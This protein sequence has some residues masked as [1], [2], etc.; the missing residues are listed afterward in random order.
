MAPRSSRAARAGLAS[1][2]ATA[3]AL[4][5]FLTAG[6]AAL[7]QPSG[8]A[9]PV[10]VVHAYPVT[11]VTGDRLVV[12]ALSNGRQAV[13]VANRSS[14]S[15]TA[16]FST[17]FH[18][19][20][21]NGDMY[22]WPVDYGPYVG[23][24][25]D[26]ELFNVSKLVR[27]GYSD[28]ASATIPLI[29]DYRQLPPEQALLPGDVTKTRSLTS[30]GAVAGRESKAKAHA[31]GQALKQQLEADA[32]AIEKGRRSAIAR[33]GPFAGVAKVYLDQKI[34][35]ALADSVPQIGAPQ[36]WAAGFTG[37]G[38]DVAVLDTGI[39]S[40]H[41]DLQ[42]K[43]VA[44]ANFTPDPTAADG[45]GHGTHVADTVAGSGTASNGLRKGVA[46]GAE[47][48]NGK[49]LDSTG[50]GQ[51]SWVIAGMQWAATNGADV[52]SMSLQAGITDGTDPVSQAVNQLTEGD[53]VLFT[54]AAGNFGSSPQTVTS[55]GAANDALTVGA[56][57]KQNVLAGFSGRG[58]RFGDFALKPDIT[59]PGVNIIAAR[60]AGT[61]LGTPIDEFYTMLSGTSMATPHIA[62]SAAIL[63]QEFPSMTPAQLK[64]A[65]MSTALPGPYTVYQQGAG[66]VDVAR[67]YSQ[68]VYSNNSP[69]DF[70]YFPYPHDNDQP[71]TKSISYSNYTSAAV[72]LNLTADVTGQDGNP[73]APGMVTTSAPSVTI[74][75]GGTASVDVTVDTRVGDPSLYGGVIRAE[76]S[77]GNVVVRTPVGFYKEPVRFN[78]TVDGIARDGRP[79]RGISWI[80]IVNADDTTRFQRTVGL[81]GGPVTVRVP[82]GT[83]S[84]MGFLFT[85][86]EPQVFATEATIAGNPQLE[87]NQDTTYTADARPAT[88]VIENTDKPTQA[89]WWVIGHYRAAEHLGSF[90]SLL[91]ASPPINRMF[92]APTQQVTKGDFGFRAK[93]NLEAPELEM[94]IAPPHAMPLDV[95]YASGA[96]KIDGS[97][98]LPLVYAGYGRVQDF[99]GLD[100]QGKAVLMTRGPLPP[101]GNPITFAEKVA[102][103]TAAGARLAII[104]NHSPG[105]LL[106]GLDPATT[107]I[108]VFSTSKIDGEQLRDLL[109]QV[110]QLTLNAKGIVQSPYAY[111]TLNAER[112]R[113]LPTHVNTWNSSDTVRI[114]TRFHAQVPSWLAGEVRHG[115]PSFS[116]FSFDGA[117]NLNVPY[118]RT[119]YVGVGG[120]NRW[121]HVAWG[122][123]TNDHIF[124]WS[125]QEPEVA[126]SQ[127]GSGT[128]DWFGQPQR[129]N[130][131]RT[132][133][134]AGENGE[135]VTR[136]GNTITGFIPSFMDA[137]GRWGTHDSRTDSAPFQL[138][139]NGT[140][141]AQSEGFFGSYGVS[142][143]P[144]SYRAELDVTRT[145]PYWTQSTNTHTTWMFDSAPPPDGVTESVPLLL[146]DY[147]LG[148]LDLQNRAHRG[149]QKIDLF[150]HRQQGAAPAS[151][152]GLTV[153]VSYDDGATWSNVP[154]TNRGGGHFGATIHNQTSGQHVSLRVK[155][156]DTGGSGITQ[157]IIRA[158]GLD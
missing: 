144:A 45:N 121:F 43:V 72:T 112:G 146:V 89:K 126:Y 66:R 65:L 38:V 56:V 14:D 147:D 98:R 64:A 99:Q 59:A 16:A 1:V 69:V 108:P 12:E 17:S 127:A 90:E 51:E 93:P 101:V 124:E 87:V 63:K 7:A 46:P 57:D 83:Y 18:A 151:V 136:T 118:T 3:L 102:N 114:D 39:D 106:I 152:T 145:A 33:T 60:A 8:Q 24:L 49:V 61:S 133:G 73:A 35:P 22:V 105:L 76:S 100:V 132:Y 111:D 40:T 148:P 68:K 77:D 6:S 11:L 79:A 2:L 154:A 10:T 135:P 157:T 71:V 109:Q 142:G 48:M 58:P 47:L 138:F 88:E 85:Y 131:I 9:A 125:Q 155:A 119:E 42:G 116:N 81:G 19:V 31:F 80:D 107:T 86:D 44:E 26:R 23:T 128:E 25:L 115:Y 5:V 13:T 110:G 137:D 84:V 29:V 15:A 141:L 113:I 37:T 94:S 21:Q 50:N 117:R 149:N 156:S 96:P 122:S 134:L 120:G 150:V 130:V 123:M 153:S 4:L 74:P 54:I 41:P 82:P 52:I 104:H 28:K 55:P 67:A 70:G 92:A 129:P 27:Q 78:L 158:F 143:S 32:P 20:R 62:G 140:Q 91:L 30:I 95:T 97:L 53:H 139:E 75:A 36:A 34:K 103:A